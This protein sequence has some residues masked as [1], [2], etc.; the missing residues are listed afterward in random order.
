MKENMRS[1]CPILNYL[2]NNN[3]INYNGK[4]LN[5]HQIAESCE[6]IFKINK[7]N[8]ILIFV[9]IF[10]TKILCNMPFFDNFNLRDI[11]KH[12][13][14]EHDA[15]LFYDDFYFTGYKSYD[16]VNINYIE[17]LIKLSK[18]RENIKMEELKI[19]KRR[20]IEHSKKYN[21]TFKYGIIAKIAS[22]IEM[23][24]L[25]NVVGKNNSISIK[26]L[27]KYIGDS[28]KLL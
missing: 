5:S 7:I 8:K 2:A 26:K 17:D 13:C 1:S 16:K 9:I 19:H 4:N 3:H 22:S 20:R 15:S 24:I 21:P 11:S 6:K 23:Y 18:D 27:K 28:N 14:L 10:I 12:N 25:L